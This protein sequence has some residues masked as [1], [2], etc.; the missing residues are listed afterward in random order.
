VP[1]IPIFIAATAI[2]TAASVAGLGLQGA[3]HHEFL[4]QLPESK[5]LI[6]LQTKIAEQQIKEYEDRQKAT[7]MFRSP[8]NI[9]RVSTPLPNLALSNVMTRSM[10]RAA[11]AQQALGQP[12]AQQARGIANPAFNMSNFGGSVERLPMERLAT[13][14]RVSQLGIAGSVARAPQLRLRAS[15]QSLRSTASDLSLNR[16]VGPF[17]T[18]IAPAARYAGGRVVIEPRPLMQQ[19]PVRQP[20]IGQ[21]TRQF[22][23]DAS[24]RLQLLRMRMGAR[25]QH[26]QYA[27]AFRPGVGRR[28]GRF[29][30]R[31]K[32]KLLIAGGALA[33]TGAF[34]GGLAGGLSG[35][36]EEKEMRENSSGVLANIVKGGGGGYGGGG[37]GGGGG[38]F[39]GFGRMAA[40]RIH[41]RKRTGGKRKTGGRRRRRTAHKR[42]KRLGRRRSGKKVNFAG[43]VIN[44]R[45][46]RRSNKKR[47]A[48]F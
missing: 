21:R 28:V 31:H 20:M 26:L 35:K 10:S 11:T 38:G 30:Q 16:P 33:G 15:S 46:R 1:L 4:K 27:P 44:K 23:N 13:T 29:L 18:G 24:A 45:R 37:G 3:Q 2:G 17:V 36:K 40:R 12:L 48:A 22:L 5:R 32:R 43:A 14:P 9:P 7:E 6:E 47:F 25:F 19:A 39:G 42:V 8:A 34:I 41:R